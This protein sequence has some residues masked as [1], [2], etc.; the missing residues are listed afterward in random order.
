MAISQNKTRIICTKED[1]KKI[2][3]LIQKLE[4]SIQSRYD[5][6]VIILELELPNNYNSNDLKELVDLQDSLLG[7]S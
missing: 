1:E 6:G 7:L 5:R 4:F 2:L 3:E